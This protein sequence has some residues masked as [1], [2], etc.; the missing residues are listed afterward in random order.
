[1]NNPLQKIVAWLLLISGSIGALV[2]FYL[3]TR[4]PRL[5]L[6][7]V[8]LSLALPLVGIVSGV[9]CLLRQRWA[10]VLGLLFY[11]VQIIRYHS[12]GLNF[13]FQSG[14][15]MMVR[16]GNIPDSLTH[17][18]PLEVNLAAALLFL[19][20]IVALVVGFSVRYKPDVS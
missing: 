12:P 4:V 3:F 13:D 2:S 15:Q 16:P 20:G 17:Q 8:A 5:T 6:S 18:P 7:D 19:L 1:M 9:G 11:A 10:A 14:F